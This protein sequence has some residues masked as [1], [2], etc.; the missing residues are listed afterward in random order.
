MQRRLT[1]NRSGS[2]KWRVPHEGLIMKNGKRRSWT[3]DSD[4]RT[5]KTLARKKTRAGIES[6][7]GGQKALL[8]KKHSVWACHSTLEFSVRRSS[9]VK[10]RSRWLLFFFWRSPVSGKERFTHWCGA[11]RQAVSDW[12]HSLQFVNKPPSVII[13]LL[14][15]TLTKPSPGFTIPLP[16]F[17]P[18]CLSRRA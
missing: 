7:L 8:D 11:R 15:A 18:L 6:S 16:C 4:V 5:L 1:S 17:F 13:P 10:K 3:T 12:R 2:A 14:R 9:W